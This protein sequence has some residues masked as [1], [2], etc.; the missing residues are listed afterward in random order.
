MVFVTMREFISLKVKIYLL[1]VLLMYLYIYLGFPGDSMVKNPPTSEGDAH[2][3]HGLGRG[4][5]RRE[6]QPIPVSLPGKSH[7]WRSLVGYSPWSHRRVG[8]SLVTKQQQQSIYPCINPSVYEDYH[9]THNN[10]C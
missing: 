6:W 3:I 5:W 7:G 2:S 10:R 9:S 1:S 4:P 8:H